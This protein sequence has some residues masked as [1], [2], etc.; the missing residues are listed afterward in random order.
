MEGNEQLRCSYPQN[1]LIVFDQAA[2]L[3]IAKPLIE[4]LAYF[5]ESALQQNQPFLLA[6][7][8]CRR[9]LDTA[10]DADQYAPFLAMITSCVVTSLTRN[11]NEEERFFGGALFEL[12]RILEHP[13]TYDIP[14]T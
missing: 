13:F 3:E 14:S 2:A 12:E 10:L 9:A 7:L 11:L 6:S 8:G 4:E 5:S 1:M